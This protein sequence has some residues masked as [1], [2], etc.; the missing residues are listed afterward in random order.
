MA[1]GKLRV[2]KVGQQADKKE[3]QVVRN[4]LLLKTTT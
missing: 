1:R 4:K 3:L 2:V